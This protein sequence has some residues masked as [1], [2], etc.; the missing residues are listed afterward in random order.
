MGVKKF[1]SN[2][3]KSL[4]IENYEG[5]GKKKSI[6]N[7]IEKLGVREIKL[8]EAIEKESDNEKLIQLHEELDVISLYIKKAN[9]KLRKLDCKS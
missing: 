7:L 3:V 4:N 5:V 1:I 6:K 9:K 2:A 8:A